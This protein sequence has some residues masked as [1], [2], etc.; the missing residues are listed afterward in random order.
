MRKINEYTTELNDH[1]ITVLCEKSTYNTDIK[2]LNDSDHVANF[3][4]EILHMDKKAEEYFFI[5]AVNTKCVPIGVFEISHGTV[6]TTIAG[7]REIFVRLF[8]C[9]AAGFF[10][11]HNHPSGE[12]TPSEQDITLTKNLVKAG[13]FMGIRLYDHIII[14]KDH[15][16]KSIRK[17]NDW[18]QFQ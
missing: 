2:F 4:R 13:N 7:I 15:A 14:G 18:S 10:A 1:G 16:Y 12:V 9:G 8:L 5:I 11:I 3:A 6:N 17:T